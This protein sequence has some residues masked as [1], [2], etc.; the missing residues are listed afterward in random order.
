MDAFRYLMALHASSAA[1]VPGVVQVTVYFE[2][3][4]SV[5]AH[6]CIGRSLARHAVVAFIVRYGVVSSF[7]RQ[8][9]LQKKYYLLSQHFSK[10]EQSRCHLRK[11]KTLTSY[12]FLFEAGQVVLTV[13][14]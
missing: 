12:V 5:A 11:E 10:L 3:R 13:K 1:Q 14:K 7:L 6:K 4:L 9:R 8:G 2:P